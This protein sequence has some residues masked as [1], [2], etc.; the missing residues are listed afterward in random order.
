MCRWRS[1]VA[2]NVIVTAGMHETK[3]ANNTSII[4]K[5]YFSSQCGFVREHLRRRH[6]GVDRR[7][8][9]A[10]IRELLMVWY[11]IIRHS[12]NTKVMVRFPKNVLLVKAQMLQQEYLASCLRNMVQPEPLEITLIWLRG[13]LNEYRVS[14][15]KPNRKYK[16]A[17]KVLA[18]RL[19]TFRLSVRKIR[20]LIQI[21][22]IMTLGARMLTNPLST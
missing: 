4:G 9:A 7:R 6:V 20:R 19:E 22:L 15:R 5:Q 17:K 2:V 3:Y 1:A 21:I 8:S 18:E 10:L 12:V 16:V 14:H 11:D 13:L